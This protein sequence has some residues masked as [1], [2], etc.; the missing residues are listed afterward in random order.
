MTQT[1]VRQSRRI[2][3]HATMTWDATSLLQTKAA[4]DD[5]KYATWLSDFGDVSLRLSGTNALCDMRLHRLAYRWFLAGLT[6]YEATVQRQ[7]C[8]LPALPISTPDTCVGC[9]RPE[10]TVGGRFCERCRAD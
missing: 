3:R 6:P 4:E 10:S 9:N 5:G 1:V 7:Q 8:R 2:S